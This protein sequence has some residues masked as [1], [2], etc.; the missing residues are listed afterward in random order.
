MR[1]DINN[2]VLQFLTSWTLYVDGMNRI[3][4]L[5]CKEMYKGGRVDMGQQSDSN[6]KEWSDDVSPFYCYLRQGVVV[7]S[8]SVEMECN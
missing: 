8:S 3:E 5:R 2:Q 1:I 4:K 6:Y 7:F